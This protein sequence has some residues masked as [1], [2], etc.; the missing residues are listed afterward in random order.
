MPLVYRTNAASSFKPPKTPEPEPNDGRDHD[1]NWWMDYQPR[2]LIS[3]GR[4]PN[5]V[6]TLDRVI[7]TPGQDRHSP[8][9]PQESFMT[10]KKTTKKALDAALARVIAKKSAPKKVANGAAKGPGVIST[11]IEMISREEGASK[12]EILKVLVK[13]FPDR[14]PDGM[15]KTIII[16]A[17]RN[18]SS[19]ETD[20]A[21]GIV[22][23]NRRRSA[24][25]SA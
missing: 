14:D 3:G 16:Q 12:D 20:D 17:N 13:R 4:P 10:A 15:G 7:E 9:Q 11:I 22:Y 21:R 25:A 5:V 18:K 8:V 1:P 23:F 19:K 6:S 24:H 2:H